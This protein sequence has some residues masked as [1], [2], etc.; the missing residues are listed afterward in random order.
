MI[1]PGIALNYKER[2]VRGDALAAAD[3]RKSPSRCTDVVIA[4]KSCPLTPIQSFA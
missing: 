3:S 4:R 2:P 1:L